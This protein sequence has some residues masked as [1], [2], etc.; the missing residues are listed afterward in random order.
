MA[1]KGKWFEDKSRAVLRDLF[2]TATPIHPEKSIPTKWD[3]FRKVDIGV[4]KPG[5]F[6]YIILECK[7]EKNVGPSAV[8]Q[9]VGIRD[10]V[11]AK[12]AALLVNG[13]ISKNALKKAKS[14]NIKVFNVI[15]PNDDR[16][17][18]HIWVKVITHFIW[19][20]KFRYSLILF[21]Q[22]HKIYGDPNEVYIEPGKTLTQF[23]KD[24]WNDGTLSRELG[25]HSHSLEKL[26]MITA[27]FLGIKTAAVDEIRIEYE[28]IR[29]SYLSKTELSKGTGLYNIPEQMFIPLSDFISFGPITLENILTGERMENPEETEGVAFIGFAYHVE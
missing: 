13:R 17:R 2:P 12:N 1:K 7:D 8:D 29:A 18:P 19:L 25:I 4:G 11:E 20:Q 10:D 22:E 21:D 15:D 24:K 16:I 9:A 23:V 26:H 6:D 28:V 3:G 14:N 5:S 27:P